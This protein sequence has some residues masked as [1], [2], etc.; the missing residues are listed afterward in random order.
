MHL[1]SLLIRYSIHQAITTRHTVFSEKD[2]DAEDSPWE[3]E[4]PAEIEE[5]EEI[6]YHPLPPPAPVNNPDDSSEEEPEPCNGDCWALFRDCGSC[7]P[8]GDG[9]W[10]EYGEN[11]ED[12]DGEE[13]EQ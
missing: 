12:Y 11:W 2:S 3:E 10:G 4:E 6:D 5:A 13:G 8:Q 9:V 1:S 7:G